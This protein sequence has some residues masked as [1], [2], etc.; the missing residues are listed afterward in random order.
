M[1][2]LPN[3]IRF[4]CKHIEETLPEVRKCKH[5]STVRKIVAKLHVTS[6]FDLDNLYSLD[7]HYH[8]DVLHTEQPLIEYQ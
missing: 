4:S 6:N 2:D 3:V 1:I 8:S 5:E 7:Y